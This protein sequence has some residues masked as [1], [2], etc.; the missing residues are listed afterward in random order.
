MV[1][2]P[3]GM[4]AAIRSAR[5]LR[6][7]LVYFGASFAALEAVDL[8]SDRIGL[9]DWLFPSAVALPIIG[10]P[11]ILATALVQATPAAPVEPRRADPAGGPEPQAAAAAEVTDS[12]WRWFTWRKAIMGGVVAFALLGVT[13]TGYMV[14]RVTGIGP[15]GSLVAKGAIEAGDRIIL[16]DFQSETG[17]TLLAAAATE[18]FRIDLSQSPVV[19]IAE[20]QY[21]GRVLQRM[22]RDP[23][24]GLDPDLAREAAVREGL[25]AT[26]EGEINSAGRG[27]VLST[28]VVA[29]D[30]TTLAAFRESAGD[31]TEVIDAI[32]DLSKDVRERIGESLKTI[33]ASEPLA[34]VTTG[35]LEAL[36]K[37]SQG[38][39]AIDAGDQERGVTLFE[40]AIE[41][42]TTFAMAYRKLGL[43]ALNASRRVEALTKA[44][45][46]RDRLTERERY[47]AMGTYYGNVTDDRPA[48]INAYRS[49]L[50]IYPNESTALN[51]LAVEYTSMRDFAG[52]EELYRRANEID[53]S[54]PTFW[55]NIINVQVA[56]GELDEAD[57]TL[58]RFS[59]A[60]PGHPDIL[61]HSALLA[62][63][64][65]EYEAAEAY[66]LELREAQRGSMLWQLNT[67]WPLAT[68]SI[69]RGKVA[70]GER[71]VTEVI[72]VA[73]QIGIEGIALG[74]TIGRGFLGLWFRGDTVGTVRAVDEA[75]EAYPLNSLATADRPYLDLAAFYA[76]AGQPERAREFIA[77]YER[78]VDP[79]VRRGNRAGLYSALGDI[80]LAEKRY[81][82]AIAEYRRWDKEIACAICASQSIALAF[83]QAGQSDSALVRYEHYLTTPWLSRVYNDFFFRAFAFERLGALYEERGDTQ[84]ALYNYGK[85][86]ELWDEAD[87]DLQ[88]RVEAARRAI[89]ALSTDR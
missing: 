26:I 57:S 85:F 27:F 48:A 19:R 35:S 5:L 76:S 60:L 79:E 46:Y 42:D 62:S 67:A 51:N 78:E 56:Q 82:A 64:R 84:N 47:L 66:V 73:E 41:L 12:A 80:A 44:Y 77:E 13:V 39:R 52:A 20:P 24:G 49:L 36:R 6:I 83:D 21:V 17:D 69:V 75:L 40:E 58:A 54:V 22:G 14:M 7:V 68:L 2:T 89:G 55:R 28:R 25:K 9:P 53:P 11:I 34:Q 38:L 61:D 30:G 33:R 71:R 70:D 18:A 50:E 23:S 8:L 59:E 43:R 65:G 88:P 31:S 81:D 37:Y 32:D 29:A 74:V 15:V 87:P 63:T 86:V 10:F 4:M 1:M 45:E 16:A 3:Q 72:S